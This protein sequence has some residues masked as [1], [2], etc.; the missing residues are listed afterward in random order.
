MVLDIITVKISADYQQQVESLMPTFLLSILARLRKYT[1]KTIWFFIKFFLKK[2]KERLWELLRTKEL[3]EF[4]KI[5][6]TVTNFYKYDPFRGVVDYTLYDLNYYFNKD[7]NNNFFYGKDCDDAAY[8]WFEYLKTKVYVDE[9]Y[10]ILCIDGWKIKTMHFFVV[11]RFNDGKYR[12]FNYE[13]VNKHFN[14]LHEAVLEMNKFGLAQI[15]QKYKDFR[16]VIYDKLIEPN[17]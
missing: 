2:P 17:N 1:A 7:N 8:V 16:W 4:N 6:K 5:M 14:T 3:V 9:V 10:N 15:P 13:M 11:A 12:L